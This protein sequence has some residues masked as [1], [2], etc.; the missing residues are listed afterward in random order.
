MPVPDYPFAKQGWYK[1]TVDAAGK[2]GHFEV[3]DEQEKGQADEG[4][5]APICRQVTQGDKRPG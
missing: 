4:H 5:A 2:A 3:Q 1:Q